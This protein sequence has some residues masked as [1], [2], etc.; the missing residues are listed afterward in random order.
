M[1]HYLL[2]EGVVEFYGWPFPPFEENCRPTN[3]FAFDDFTA[4]INL[5]PKVLE[6]QKPL[7]Q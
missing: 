4:R 2:S 5:N 7:D 3:G 1:G 6:A